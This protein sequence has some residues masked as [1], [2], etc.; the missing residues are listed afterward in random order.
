[1]SE[2]NE[3]PALRRADSIFTVPAGALL[4]SWETY[5]EVRAA[6]EDSRIN[7]LLVTVPIAIVAGALG[8]PPVAVFWLN[9]LAIIPLAPLIWLSVVEI[10]AVTEHHFGGFLRSTCVNGVEMIVS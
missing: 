3:R 6:Y 9:F 4:P 10:S 5:Q 2:G 1:M 8:W 7:L